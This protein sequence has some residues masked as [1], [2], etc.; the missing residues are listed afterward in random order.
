MPIPS[1][2][3]TRFVQLVV[4]KQ[5]AEAEREL[6]RLKQKMHKTEW[7]RGYFRALYGILLMRS[8][9]ND[10]YSFLAKLN[11][12]DKPTLQAYRKE[13][14]SH[15]RNKLHGDFDR[16]FFSAW[17]DF[18]RLLSRMDFNGAEAARVNLEKERNLN[19]E[20]TQATM[21]EFLE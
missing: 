16:G 13:F 18:T 12:N 4:N 11:L 15:V 2:L 19:M 10:P 8:S 7:N 1:A 9:N 21:E 14:L 6:E 3:V 20:K 5:F 17:A